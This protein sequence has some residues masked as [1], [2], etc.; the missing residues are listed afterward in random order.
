MSCEAL[1]PTERSGGGSGGT[2]A[3]RAQGQNILAGPP[4]PGAR[5]H[6]HARARTLKY[7]QLI[8]LVTMRQEGYFLTPSLPSET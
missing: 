2:I 1:S 4:C 7:V 8:H 5:G 6:I 3:D